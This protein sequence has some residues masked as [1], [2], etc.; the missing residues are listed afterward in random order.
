MTHMYK[1]LSVVALAAVLSVG[2]NAEPSGNSAARIPTTTIA[3]SFLPAG[4]E[5][6]A[7]FA[8]LDQL[9][10]TMAVAVQ[11]N[12]VRINTD[13]LAD[14]STHSQAASCKVSGKA[15]GVSITAPTCSA[16]LKEFR[17]TANATLPKSDQL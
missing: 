6:I 9:A 16:A 3:Q 14:E 1:Y 8:E 4:S 15:D 11:I 12:E 13:K 5:E 17:E 7:K 10:A 2:V